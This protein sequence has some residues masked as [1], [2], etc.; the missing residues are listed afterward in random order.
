MQSNLISFQN[1]QQPNTTVNSYIKYQKLHDFKTKLHLSDS[2]TPKP[3]N[4]C[5]LLGISPPKAPTANHY[6]M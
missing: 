3:E 2:L 1:S 6:K 4:F 5:Q